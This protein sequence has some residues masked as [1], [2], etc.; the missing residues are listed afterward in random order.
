MLRMASVRFS[1]AS[2][3]LS[4]MH[5]TSYT[6]MKPHVSS[7]LWWS[8]PNVLG[9]NVGPRTGMPCTA[10]SMSVSMYFTEL[11]ISLRTFSRALVLSKFARPL[12]E[13]S[14][15]R[16]VWKPRR[17]RRNACSSEAL[18]VL[19]VLARLVAG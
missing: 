2:N 7:S 16:M 4:K 12:S 6:T 5:L 11:T 17:S 18:C 13:P 19:N 14:C 3:T 1:T 10:S 9:P 8:H 15:S